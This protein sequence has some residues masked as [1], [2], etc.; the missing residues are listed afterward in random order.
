MVG[1]TAAVDERRQIGQGKKIPRPAEVSAQIKGTQF[2]K[3][4]ADQGTDL[5]QFFSLSFQRQVQAR[6]RHDIFDCSG[7]I[8]AQTAAVGPANDLLQGKRPVRFK[9]TPFYF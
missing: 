8:Q 9:G 2:G 3:C 1:L 6:E 5:G 4:R 7:C